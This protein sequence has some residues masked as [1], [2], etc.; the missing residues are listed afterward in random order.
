MM[1][2]HHEPT[3]EIVMQVRNSN[4]TIRW[5][6]LPGNM[7][8]PAGFLPCI[9]PERTLDVQTTPS[10]LQ[11]ILALRPILGMNYEPTPSDRTGAPPP[12]QGD[13]DYNNADFEGLWGNTLNMGTGTCTTTP[14]SGTGPRNDIANMKQDLNVNY[15]RSFNLAQE[16]FRDHTVFADYCATNNVSIS[17]P[18]DFWVF[19]AGDPTLVPT[20]VKSLG[21]KSATVCW[22][23][24][25][26]L[27]GTAAAGSIA[28]L[29]KVIVDTEKANGITPHPMTSSLQNGLFPSMAILIKNAIV[30]LGATYEQEYNDRWFQAVNVY[31]ADPSGAPTAELNTIINTTWPNSDFKDQPLLI[32]EYGTACN[33]SSAV[34]ASTVMAQAQFIKDAAENPAKPLFLGGCLF[35]YTNELWKTHLLYSSTDNIIFSLSRG[36][37]YSESCVQYLQICSKSCP[38]NRSYWGYRNYWSGWTYWP[39]W[40]LNYV[41]CLLSFDKRT[42]LVRTAVSTVTPHKL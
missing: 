30:A 34:Q 35:E 38:I 26:E 19:W 13:T 42:Y 14:G 4:G 27:N 11:K 39:Y 21:P 16:A 23:L 12:G 9:A 32:T 8:P 41:F 20:L 6:R 18:M 2:F 22:R 25:N 1:I 15:I 3:D 40:S 28:N 36:C 37:S 33:V 29:F 5:V 17:W 10:V 31:P 24:G 7:G